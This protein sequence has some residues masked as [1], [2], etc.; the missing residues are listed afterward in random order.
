MHTYIHGCIHIYIPIHIYTY[1]IQIYIYVYLYT[2]GTMLPPTTPTIIPLIMM[3]TILKAMI[4][5]GIY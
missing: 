1:E 5:V 2:S 4:L 3:V